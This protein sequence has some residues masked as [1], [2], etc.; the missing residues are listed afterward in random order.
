MG[1][2]GFRF[3]LAPTLG[4]QENDFDPFAAFFLVGQDPVV[5][6]VKLIAEPWDVG[7][8]DTYDLGRFPPLGV[9]G[10]GASATPRATSG[11]AR[12]D[13]WAS[14]PP[15]CVVPRTSTA[16]GSRGARIDDFGLYAAGYEHRDDDTSRRPTAIVVAI[17]IVERTA[18]ARRTAM[19][20][21]DIDTSA[22]LQI[23]MAAMIAWVS[24]IKSFGATAT[25]QPRR[26][27]L[28]YTRSQACAPESTT[29]GSLVRCPKGE[30]APST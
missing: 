22:P 25:S 7:R 5:S 3:D 1:V 20:H 8:F 23:L 28:Q 2:D 15:G 21:N 16:D 26:P 11:A 19:S 10:T 30:T 13:C 24:R 6:Q 29:V 27:A 4:R 14:S 18:G 17:C 9:S 12:T